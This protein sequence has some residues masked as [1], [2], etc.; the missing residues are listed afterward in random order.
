MVATAVPSLINEYVRASAAP[1]HLVSDPIPINQARVRVTAPHLTLT[2]STLP[3]GHTRVSSTVDFEHRHRLS[4]G[5]PFLGRAASLTITHRWIE[6][7][8]AKVARQ[9]RVDEGIDSTIR[10]GEIGAK[11]SFALEASG[12]HYPL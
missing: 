4:P 10:E 12:L 9:Q 1:R 8:H 2:P 6:A 5:D 3:D 7:E 11:T